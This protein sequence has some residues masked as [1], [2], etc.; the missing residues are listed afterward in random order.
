M[1]VP[2]APLSDSAMSRSSVE[3]SAVVGT[4]QRTLNLSLFKFADGQN[5]YKTLYIL[6]QQ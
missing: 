4:W 3:I 2:L 6:V 5:F 1:T